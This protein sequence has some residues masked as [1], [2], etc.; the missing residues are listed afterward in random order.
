MRENKALITYSQVYSHTLVTKTEKHQITQIK[1]GKKTYSIAP[2]L[3][4]RF[5]I[6]PNGP[7]LLVVVTSP[8]IHNS[9]VESLNT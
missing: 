6:I 2:F 5:Y 9:I 4:F 7:N 8:S 3:R 1:R